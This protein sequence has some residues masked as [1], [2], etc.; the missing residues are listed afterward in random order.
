MLFENRTRY[1][2]TQLIIKVDNQVIE[3]MESIQFSKL[4]VDSHLSPGQSLLTFGGTYHLHFQ[5]Q[6]LC[7]VF[8][9]EN[10]GNMLLLSVIECT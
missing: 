10:G 2:P 3:K 4:Q 6:R 1:R 8:D 5:G 9:T 7:Q